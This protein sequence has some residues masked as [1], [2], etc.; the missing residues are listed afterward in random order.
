MKK[1]LDAGR[2][3]SPEE[4]GKLLQDDASFT[5]AHQTLAV[6]GQ[7]DANPEEVNHHYVVF[8]NH[9]NQLY[10]LDGRKSFPIKHGETSADTLLEVSF[11]F[12][13]SLYTLDI[14]YFY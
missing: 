7:T 11:R 14:S 6:E 3:L 9:D 4:R 13:S 12:K 2:E 8:V 1:Y 5:E 10:E